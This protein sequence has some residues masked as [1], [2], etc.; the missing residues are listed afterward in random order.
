MRTPIPSERGVRATGLAWAGLGLLLTCAVSCTTGP[1][2]TEEKPPSAWR[3]EISGLNEVGPYLEADLAGRAIADGDEPRHFYFPAS[4][5]CQAALGFPGEVQYR[6]VGTFGKLRSADGDRCS[7]NGIGS[8]VAWR[9]SGRNLRSEP[10]P[11]RVQAEYEPVAASPGQ[12][13]VRGRFP[14]T[15]ELRWPEPMDTVVVLPAS[16]EC[17]AL[18]IEGS[19]TMEYRTTGEHVFWLEGTGGRCP[20]IGLAVPVAP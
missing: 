12:L 1:K 11:P 7:P 14:L 15:L 18:S 3:V 17:E 10:I 5:E 20:I 6:S 4:P 16:P 19:A 2:P 8:L 9:D 13:L